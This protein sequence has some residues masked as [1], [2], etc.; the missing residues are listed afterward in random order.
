MWRPPGLN[1]WLPFL[2]TYINDLHKAPSLQCIHYADDTTLFSKINNF[3]DLFDFT[4]AELVKKKG[5]VR[6]CQ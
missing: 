5:H 6:L 4:N 2:I 1:T 3:E